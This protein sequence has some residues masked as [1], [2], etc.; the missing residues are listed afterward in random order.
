MEEQIFWLTISLNWVKIKNY[1]NFFG[2]P[3]Q[4]CSWRV[5]PGL[6]LKIAPQLLP[7]SR[8]TFPAMPRGV[9]ICLPFWAESVFFNLKITW[10]VFCNNILSEISLSFGPYPSS[11]TQ[12]QRDNSIFNVTDPSLGDWTDLGS[13]TSTNSGFQPMTLQL[14]SL[15]PQ[16]VRQV[17]RTSDLCNKSA[18]I[19]AELVAVSVP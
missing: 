11:L 3:H 13:E 18:Q 9:T 19:L 2:L 6:N 16:K 4:F 14:P 15:G 10:K 8:L 1:H 12:L 7:T 17:G 5:K